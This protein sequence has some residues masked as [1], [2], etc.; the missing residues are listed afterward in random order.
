MKNLVCAVTVA[1]AAVLGSGCSDGGKQAD[2]KPAAGTKEDPR[3]KP[4]QAD[5]GRGTPVKS[6][7]PQQSQGASKAN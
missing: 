1:C 3:I 5:D 6:S 7:G 2:P 4:I